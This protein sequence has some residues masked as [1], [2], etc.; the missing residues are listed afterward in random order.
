MLGAG[1]ESRFWSS[2]QPLLGVQPGGR[3]GKI[4]RTG[5]ARCRGGA[6]WSLP[7]VA[8]GVLCFRAG[9]RGV[10]GVYGREDR[11]GTGFARKC[12]P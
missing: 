4:T 9:A 12:P 11:T 10:V 6:E 2:V 7:S 8:W 1:M 3:W 5:P